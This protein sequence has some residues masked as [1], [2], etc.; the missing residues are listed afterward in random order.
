MP[1]A[2]PQTH[3]LHGSTLFTSHSTTIH[4]P[5]LFGEILFDELPAGPLPGGGPFN[6]A[7]HLAALGTPAALLTAVGEDA[8]GRELTALAARL[9]VD[10]RLFQRNYLPT[11]SVAVSFDADGEPDYDIVAPVAWDLLRWPD[12]TDPDPDPALLALPPFVADVDAVVFWLLGIRSKVS[13]ACLEQVLAQAPAAALRVMDVGLR[14]NFYDAALLDWA[15]SRVR[16]AKLNASELAEV[17]EL[18]GLATGAEVLAKAYRLDTLVVTLGEEGAYSWREGRKTSVGA[19]P[20][21]HLVDA[22]GCGDSFLAGYLHARL[23]GASEE[24]CLRAGAERG[25]YTAGRQG[26]L[27]PEPT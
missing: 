14:Q 13:R 3:V 5:L 8:R 25:A 27:P 15:L 2:R 6:A 12:G 10:T 16:V 19:A 11:G 24:A 1:D 17:S 18:L 21:P 22:I 9:G 7:A 4:S 20:V 26:G 23:R